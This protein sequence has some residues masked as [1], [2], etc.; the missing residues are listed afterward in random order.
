M[1]TEL[2]NAHQFRTVAADLL[3]AAR[4]AHPV[5][6]DHSPN[7]AVVL[8]VA[9]ALIRAAGSRT[10]VGLKSVIHTAAESIIDGRRAKPATVTHREADIATEALLLAR[11]WKHGDPDAADMSL[12]QLY[13]RA[14]V[15]AMTHDLVD[16]LA[17]IG[18]AVQLLQ[19]IETLQ[20]GVLAQLAGEIEKQQWVAYMTEQFGDNK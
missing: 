16:V 1:T 2:P 6:V 12:Q 15:W 10:D 19:F 11:P 3:G 7:P 8:A 18:V 9:A 13:D 14:E 20:P 17:V 4:A 5:I